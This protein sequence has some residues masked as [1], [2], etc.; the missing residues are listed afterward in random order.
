M[1]EKMYTVLRNIKEES[2][3]DSV[4]LTSELYDSV[5]R[6]TDKNFIKEYYELKEKGCEAIT[7]ELEKGLHEQGFLMS[8][9]EINKVISE[10]TESKKSKLDLTIM[11]TE[12]C[13][14]RCIYCYEDHEPIMMDR[15][16]IESLKLFLKNQI[17]NYNCISIAWFGGEPTLCK[18]AILDINRTVQVMTGFEQGKFG[19]NMTTNGYLLDTES[20]LA[21]YE[22]G[23]RSYQITLDGWKHDN[24][25]PLSNG[26][27]SLEQIIKNLDE[28][29][30]LPE[31]FKFNIVLRYNIL[32]G[33][34]DFT[35][36]DYLDKKYGDD[37]RFCIL[38]RTV[39]D[40]GGEQVK[41]L[42][43]LK[44]EQRNNLMQEHVD[45][46]HKLKIKAITIIWII[47]LGWEVDGAM[48][49]NQIIL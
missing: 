27:G 37:S 31:E 47:I 2:N 49:L 43:L 14:F 38:V 9:D 39:N 19:S 33:D 41:N 12:G 34:R 32:P 1:G 15:K 22:H 26:K 40:M 44:G 11:P 18:D 13:N 46:I 24:N 8:C 17:Q 6:L 5:I 16:L 23:I 29:H 36:Y 25:R 30:N 21:Y 35:W 20:F 7:T 10:I 3:A 42:E 4:V 45:Y 28:I 48:Q